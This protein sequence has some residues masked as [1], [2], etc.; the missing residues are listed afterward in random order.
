MTTLQIF[1]E[2]R[3]ASLFH[4]NVKIVVR[5]II[6]IYVPVGQFTKIPNTDVTLKHFAI[7]SRLVFFGI[8]HQ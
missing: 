4:C 3:D 6:G 5:R 2:S 8:F 1:G 7:F